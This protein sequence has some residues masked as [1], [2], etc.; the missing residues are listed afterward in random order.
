MNERNRPILTMHAIS[1]GILL[2]VSLVASPARA[3]TA[4]IHHELQVTLR[5]DEHLLSAIDSITLPRDFPNEVAFTLHAGLKPTSP[6]PLVSIIKRSETQGAV[7]LEQYIVVLPPG[8]RAF[9]VSYEG[10][11]N[12]PLEEIGKEQARG[13]QETPGT[14]SKEGVY[15]AS[16]SGWHPDLGPTLVTFDLQ[17][18]LPQSWNAVSQGERT[19]LDQ[20]GNTVSVRWRSPEPQDAI[21]LI[22]AQFTEYTKRAGPVL[23]MAFLRTPDQELADKYLDATVTYLD[24]Y[25]KLIGPYPYKK[26]ALVENFWETGLGMPSFTLL[27]SK[28]LRLPFLI[29]TSYPHEILHNWWGNSVFL[30]YEKGNWSEGLTAYLADHLIKEQQGMGAE[31]RMNT[32]QKY[33][34]YVIGNRD[35]PLT[36]FRSRH[37]SSSE[38][39]GYG[40]ALMFFHQLRRELGD[41]TFELGLQD[42]FQK[43]KFR[44]AAF[45]DL[46][47]SFTT[48]S[49]KDLHTQFEQWVSR[50]GA[51]QLKAG[52]PA[53]APVEGGFLLSALLEQTQPGE[54]YRLQIPVAVTMEGVE[55][56]FQTV[57]EMNDKSMELKVRLTRRPLRLDIDPEFD[58]F[59]RLD[60]EEVPPAISQALGAKKMLLLLPSASDKKLLAAYRELAKTISRSGPDEVELKLDSEVK[61]LPDDR[62]VTILGWE[63][64]FLKTMLP[65]LSAHDTAF[66][67]H[68]VRIN[69]TEIPKQDHSFVFTSR[70]PKHKD[71]AMMFIAARAPGA[72][73]G[74]GQKLS[75]YHKYSYLAFEGMEPA[76]IAKGRW[77]VVDSPMTVL[78]PSAGGRTIRVEPAKLSHR[79]PL[80]LL[81]PAFSREHL[82][83]SVRYLSSNELKGRGFGSSGLDKAAEY[84]ARQFQEAGLVPGGDAAESWYQVWEDTG[85][86]PEQKAVMKNVIGVIPGKKQAISKESVVVAAHYDHLGFG[87]PESRDAGTGKVHPGADDNASGVAVLIE[88]AKTFAK[89]PKPDRTIVFVAFTGEEAGKRGSRHYVVNEHR[90]PIEQCIAMLNLDT[91]GRLGK[92]KLLVLGAGSAKEW[93]HIF[94][95]AGFVTGVE[96]ETVSLDLDSSD[97][98]TFQEAGVPAVQLFSGPNA[99]Y[100]RTTDTADKIDPEG[101]VKV[102]SVAREAIEY[103]TRREGPLSAVG[104]PVKSAKT[105]DSAGRKVSLGTIP[106]FAYTGTGLRITG[107]IPGSPAE[108]AGLKEGDVITAINA[109]PLAGLQDFSNILKRSSPGDKITVTFLRNGT[110]M[111]VEATLQAK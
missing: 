28:V 87:W 74:L 77:P 58:L 70:L 19:M 21:F 84:I 94:R 37:S 1:I 53:L 24:L 34:D 15:L 89:G 95:G 39:V 76:N 64:M 105:P 109:A 59:R 50:E 88:L 85:G 79:D 55:Q 4:Y 33:A 2:L 30:D 45:D 102:A 107:T 86:D 26:F 110:A 92:K 63:N 8:L 69:R 38:A 36:Q 10:T 22:A 27:G 6:T 98:I 90:W 48:V 20:G 7:P 13:M 3:E 61:A 51:P 99:D 18:K 93:V 78:V 75:H 103:L 65:A 56:A 42:F 97:Q 104:T 9:V 32:L 16:S 80:A 108:T 106:D 52:K 57:V 46:R 83:D 49:G 72:L 29:N 17:V 73:P 82:V 47:A 60:R 14:I 91:V 68:A 25:S 31:Y 43:N 5:P 54:A 11:I 111:S 100:H 96:I 71:L 67:K 12:H 35:F 62:A 23:A 101:L 41:E 81:A 44:F 40:K 66:S